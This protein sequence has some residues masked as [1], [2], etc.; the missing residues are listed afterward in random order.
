[1]ITM[2]YNFSKRKKEQEVER[3]TGE[4]FRMFSDREVKILLIW[5]LVGPFCALAYIIWLKY[6]RLKLV[7]VLFFMFNL[8]Y[9]VGQLGGWLYILPRTPNILGLLF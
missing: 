2:K 4:F 9:L 8:V 3:A 5:A 6:P 1:M 7:S